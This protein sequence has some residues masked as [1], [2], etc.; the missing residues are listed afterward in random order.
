MFARL[1]FLCYYILRVELGSATGGLKPFITTVLWQLA[2]TLTMGPNTSEVA[3]DMLAFER[4]MSFFQI[5]VV[6]CI[7]EDK[8]T[9]LNLYLT[10]QH[11]RRKRSQSFLKILA[12]L[13]VL[14]KKTIL[15]SRILNPTP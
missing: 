12:W 13:Y 1:L 7:K 14:K 11:L 5:L 8:N 3:S 4:K 6:I 2:T 9:S 15:S 10:C